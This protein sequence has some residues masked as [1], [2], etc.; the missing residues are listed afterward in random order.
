MVIYPRLAFDRL[1]SSCG[2]GMTLWIC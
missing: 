2:R 1:W